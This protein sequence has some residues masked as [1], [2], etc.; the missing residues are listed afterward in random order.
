MALESILVQACRELCSTIHGEQSLQKTKNK[1][2]LHFLTMFCTVRLHLKMTNI[3]LVV[4]FLFDLVLKK[5]DYRSHRC[6]HGGEEVI[7]EGVRR[8]W[9]R[10][11]SLA[12]Y[13]KNVNKNA[14]KLR[15]KPKI[16]YPTWNFSPKSINPSQGFSAKF[17]F[18]FSTVCTPKLLFCFCL[19]LNY[20][21]GK[22]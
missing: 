19:M 14:I 1:H 4:C 16:V 6:T 8:I 9:H 7:G 20:N 10:T 5:Y 13:Q 15:L 12:N 17:W 11:L 3:L 22:N 21:W 2:F 18:G